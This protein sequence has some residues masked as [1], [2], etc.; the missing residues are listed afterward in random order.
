MD[1]NASN[2]LQIKFPSVP[3]KTDK[4]KTIVSGGVAK[5]DINAPRKIQYKL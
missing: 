5:I 3:F 2:T 1:G 4:V